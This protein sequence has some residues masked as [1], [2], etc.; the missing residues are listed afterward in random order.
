LDKLKKAEKEPPR[1]TPRA[2]YVLE[3]EEQ[4]EEEEEEQIYEEEVASPEHYLS[5]DSG[6]HFVE[7]E[8]EEEEEEEEEE[9]P[10]ARPMKVTEGERGKREGTMNEWINLKLLFPIIHSL[11]I[12]RSSHFLPLLAC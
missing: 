7:R 5:P 4:L 1:A 2:D 12:D 10:Y 6:V 11:I 3:E 9:Q 8:K